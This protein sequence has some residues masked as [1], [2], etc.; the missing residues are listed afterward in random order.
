MPDTPNYPGDTHELPR[1]RELAP[2]ADNPPVE[3]VALR[4]DPTKESAPRMIAHGKGYNADQIVE[5]AEK[6]GI[7]INRDP[8][9]VSVLGALDI[10]AEIPPDL[11]N[12][13]AEVLAWAYYADRA[14][15]FSNRAVS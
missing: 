3:A 7:P 6:L 15:E 12:V 14:S 4:Y 1:G 10:G 9:L 11:F 2:V 8:T 13:I 5:I